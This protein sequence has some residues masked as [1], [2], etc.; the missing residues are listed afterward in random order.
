MLFKT[1]ADQLNKDISRRFQYVIVEF[2]FRIM[3]GWLV[4][5]FAGADEEKASGDLLQEPSE[6][7]GG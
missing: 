1:V 2:V 7:F 4:R 6:V 3:E 5:A